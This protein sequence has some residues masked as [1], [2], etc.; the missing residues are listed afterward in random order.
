MGKERGFV[1]LR[2]LITLAGILL[3]A[4]ALCGALA[5]AVRR[6]AE[7]RGRIGEEQRYRDRAVGERLK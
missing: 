3:C 4:A 2:S 7:L 5:Q 1:L 6:S